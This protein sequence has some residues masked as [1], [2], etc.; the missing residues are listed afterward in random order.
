LRIDEESGIVEYGGGETTF[1]VRG[2]KGF[3]VRLRCRWFDSRH[4]GGEPVRNRFDG[5]RERLVFVETAE[6]F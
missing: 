4:E 3:E 1:N 2:T 6:R 5:D